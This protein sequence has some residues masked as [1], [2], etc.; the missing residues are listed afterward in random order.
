MGTR[1]SRGA[2]RRE[3]L[4]A[5]AGFAGSAICSWPALA[6][7]S[8]HAGSA[9]GLQRLTAQPVRLPLQGPGK[10]ETAMWAYNATVPGPT[11]RFRQGEP[12]RF[13]LVNRLP[14]PTTVHC[15]GIRL[16]NAMDGVPDVT[17]A[18]VPPGGRF[19]YEFTP[20]DAGTYW[21]HPH[22]QTSEQ[23]GR[24]LAGALIVEERAPVPVDRDLVWLL[25]DWRLTQEGAVSEDFDAPMDALH[26][27]RYGNLVTLNGKVA[28]VVP[29]RAGERLR[30]RLINAASARIFVLAFPGHQPWVVA[31][32]GQ[33]TAPRRPDAGVVVLAPAERV[34]LI[35][36]MTGNPGEAF[37]VLD[38]AR[39][40]RPY[41]VAAL[42]YS[43]DTPLRPSPPDV[44]VALV[45]N[46]LPEPDLGNSVKA[47]VVLSGGAMGRLPEAL[48]GALR[49]HRMM[50]RGGARK[51]AQFWAFNDRALMK[52]H[53]VPLVTVPR[54]QTLVLALENQTH[55]PHPIHLHGFAFRVLSRNGKPVQP[56]PW[57]DTVL[58][59][60]EETAEIAFVADNPG[61]WMFHCHIL[62]HQETGMMGIVRVS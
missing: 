5:V 59:D 11:L 4:A 35:V 42:A 49:D 12:A 24:G 53:D 28:P 2:S 57:R 62:E 47:S 21:Y 54:G 8:D 15:H 40:S 13:E 39:P 1:E 46:P 41:A 51:G 56:A 44:P 34:D 55:W 60:A 61:D 7:D 22:F 25:A 37:E 6:A 3:V 58:L 16:P 17:Q 48:M 45:A 50:E 43:D 23:L 38:G 27:G 20:P 36:D 9:L 18:A 31:L 52:A 29:V 30:L 10:P 32:D 26:A 33:P 19:V 14:E